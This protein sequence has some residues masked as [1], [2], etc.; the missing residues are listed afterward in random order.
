MRLAPRREVRERGDRLHGLPEPHLVAEDHPLLRERE[1]RTERLVAPQGDPQ[2][3]IV[4]PQPAHPV[5][6]PRRKEPLGGVLVGPRA[7]HL[8]EQAVVLGGPQLEVDPRREVRLRGPQ[9]IDRH[10][11]EQQRKPA[12]RRLR[13]HGPDRGD[14]SERRRTGLPPGEQ[15][16]QPRA[17]RS[18]LGE[19]RLQPPDEPPGRVHGTPDVRT[20]LDQS[21]QRHDQGGRGLVRRRHVDPDGDRVPDRVRDL[22]RGGERLI[23]S[24]RTDAGDLAELVPIGLMDLTD[25]RVVGLLD[26]A[27][28]QAA[29][30]DVL[31]PGYRDRGQLTVDQEVEDRGESGVYGVGRAGVVGQHD[32]RRVEQPFGFCD[33]LPGCLPRRRPGVPRPG[34]G[35]PGL[36]HVRTSVR[37]APLPPCPAAARVRHIVPWAD[38][39]AGPAEQEPRCTVRTR[40]DGVRPG[41]AARHPASWRRT[42]P[43]PG[44]TRCAPP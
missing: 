15:H 20:G 31:E 5:R 42:A 23:G 32:T 14:G 18:G 1:A 16:A 9:Q 10:L 2:M 40:A 13:D 7:R 37:A 28:A 27:E 36:C 30:G 12:I 24:L 35:L 33:Q 4:E 25:R 26:R 34:T 22:A 43:A 17:G 44:T 21:V 11:P 8:G 19:Q 6:D 3:R 38:D 39:S 41:T 29:L